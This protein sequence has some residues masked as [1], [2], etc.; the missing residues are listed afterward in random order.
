MFLNVSVVYHLCFSVFPSK[1]VPFVGDSAATGGWVRMTLSQTPCLGAFTVEN[2]CL[3][4]P[5]PMMIRLIKC[6]T[7]TFTSTPATNPF[8][9]IDLNPDENI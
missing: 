3:V 6:K 2:C 8:G 7:I 4:M 9:K 1:T 5:W